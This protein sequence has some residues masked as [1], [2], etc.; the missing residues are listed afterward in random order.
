MHQLT[1]PMFKPMLQ[2]AWYASKL[3]EERPIF[4]NMIFV[5]QSQLLKNCAFVKLEVLYNVLIVEKYY[6]LHVFMLNTILIYVIPSKMT[7]K[8][9]KKYLK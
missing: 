8:T 4:L 3:L 1:A 5:F 2:Y 9:N 6:V 7:P